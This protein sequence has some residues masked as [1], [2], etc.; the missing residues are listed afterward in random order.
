MSYINRDG[1]R[2]VGKA[3]H[4]LEH[5][6]IA[7]RVI[8]KPLPKGSIV[9]HINGDSLDNR[10]ENLVICP[11]QDYHKLIHYREEALK[12][13]GNAN[14]KKC[15]VCKQYDDPKNLSTLS[16][17]RYTSYHKACWAKQAREKRQHEA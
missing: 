3:G 15:F 17:R 5:R 10:K 7:Q 1:Y 11:N 14:Y 2:L 4:D 12:H 9:H 8:G 6:L 13:S 16:T